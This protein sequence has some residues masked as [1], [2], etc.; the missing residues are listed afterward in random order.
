[1]LEQRVPPAKS[2]YRDYYANIRDVLLGT[3]QPAVTPQHALDVMRILE[4]ARESSL[5]RC[6]I[7]WRRD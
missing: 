3:A 1:M 5:R 7:D 4:L 6:T 2:D